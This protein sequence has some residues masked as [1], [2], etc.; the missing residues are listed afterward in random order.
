M[1]M[2][3]SSI[4]TDSLESLKRAAARYQ[5]AAFESDSDNVREVLQDI[6]YDRCEQQAAVFNLMH[7]MG[8]YKT[9]PAHSSDVERLIQSFE[10]GKAEMAQHHADAEGDAARTE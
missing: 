7:Q 8:M 9:V 4:L 1:K 6:M 3:E 10:R 2:K 5:E